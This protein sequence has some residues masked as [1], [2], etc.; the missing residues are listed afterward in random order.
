MHRL[1]I[2]G[3]ILLLGCGKKIHYDDTDENTT[4]ELPAFGSEESLDIIT[5]NLEWF[6]KENNTTIDYVVDFITVLKPDVIALQEITSSL[7]FES[8]V[9]RLD[10]YI[11]F[12][13]GGGSYM[14]LAYLIN[15]DTVEILEGPFEIYNYENH[16]FAYR[17]P[18]VIKIKYNQ[19][20]FF[21]INNHFKCCGDGEIETDLDQQYW[22]EEY[23]RLQATLLL[24]EYVETILPNDKVIILGD[25]NDEIQ[26]PEV[27]NVFW[28]IIADTA[29][30][31]FTDFPIANGNVN[32]WSYPTWPSHL[33]H[34]IITNELFEL[35][36]NP[37]SKVETLLLEEALS[38]GWNDYEKYVSDHRPVAIQLQIVE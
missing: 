18:L 19:S 12:R 3:L 1:L 16:F 32:N 26:D 22:D 35:Y 24:E 8:L 9:D 21:I 5:W 30:Y 34:I 33:D 20:E 31:M 25:L 7:Y 36:S 6:P 29:N 15:N 11:G 10:S 17:Q 13:A 27:D 38:G 23:R 37:G 14:E 2:I 4:I 28:S